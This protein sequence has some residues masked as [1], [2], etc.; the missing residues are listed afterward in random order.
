MNVN[1]IMNVCESI[2]VELSQSKEVPGATLSMA[3]GYK[4][5]DPYMYDTI[6]QVVMKADE[7]MYAKKQKMKAEMAAKAA[8]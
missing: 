5:Y 4:S 7:M 3:W 2:N 6:E 1:E 8:N